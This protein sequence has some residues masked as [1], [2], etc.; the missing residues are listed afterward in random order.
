MKGLTKAETLLGKALADPECPIS[1]EKYYIATKVG[2]YGIDKFDFSAKRVT[3]S[4]EEILKRLGLEYIDL[5]QCHD[6]EFTRLDQIVFDTLPALNKLKEEGKVRYIGITG[7][8]LKI[9]RM[10][11]EKLEQNN[12]TYLLDTILSYCHYSLNNNTLEKEIPYFQSFGLGIINAS[13]LSMGLLT[14]HGPP[15]W[16]PASMLIKD[17]CYKAVQHCKSSGQEIERLALQYS[18][19]NENIH[20]TLVGTASLDEVTKNIYWAEE[21]LSNGFNQKDKQLLEEVNSILKP[22]Q[23]KSWISGLEENNEGLQGL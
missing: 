2:R 17:T 5:I 7:F 3:E 6:I 20:T 21:Y 15:K 18:L 13:P 10:V 23:N 22:I 4:V 8:P 14:K 19:S 1:R 12:S 11:V 16:N 9:F